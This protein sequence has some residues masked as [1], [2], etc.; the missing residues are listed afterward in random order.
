MIYLFEK[1]SN[2]EL[3]EICTNCYAELSS[4]AEVREFEPP[5]GLTCGLLDIIR[6]QIMPDKI[7]KSSRAEF[8]V[9]EMFVDGRTTVG[10]TPLREKLYGK[11]FNF[12]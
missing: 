4:R 11:R 8:W 5:K 2:F 10:V 12:M 1:Q 9:T 3:T 7:S 6:Y